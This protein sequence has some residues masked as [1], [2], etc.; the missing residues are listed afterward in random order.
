VSTPAVCPECLEESPVQS[1]RCSRCGTSLGAARPIPRTEPKSPL[2]I[3]GLPFNREGILELKDRSVPRRKTLLGALGAVA[4]LIFVLQ[5]S[6]TTKRAPTPIRDLHA[7]WVTT[8]SIAVAWQSTD[9]TSDGL[10]FFAVRIS[11]TLGSDPTRGAALV[12]TNTSG[13][14]GLLSGTRYVVSVTSVATNGR[15]SAA[16]V[17]YVTTM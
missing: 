5:L 13:T 3:G 9:R 15:R 4:I 8:H 6:P 14:N 11:Q 17:I 7:T 16:D 1:S 2:A 10:R 12:T